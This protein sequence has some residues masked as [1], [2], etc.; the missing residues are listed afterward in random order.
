VVKPALELGRRC[1]S[2]QS[3]ETNTSASASRAGPDSAGLPELLFTTEVRTKSNS[4]SAPLPPLRCFSPTPSISERLTIDTQKASH[5]GNANRVERSDSTIAAVAVKLP[6]VSAGRMAHAVP[7]KLAG[8]AA[9]GIRSELGD[10]LTNV[11]GT[12]LRVPGRDDSH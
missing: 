1:G 8:A 3:K 7:M 12:G 6:L 9:Q 2:F 4:L 5:R 10:S 11:P